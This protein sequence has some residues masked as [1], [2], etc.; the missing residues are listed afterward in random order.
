MQINNNNYS[1]LELIQMLE[2]KELIV[3]KDYQRGSGLWPISARA[4]FI[5]TILQGFPFPKIYMYEYLD[6]PARGMKK[7]I[8]DGQQ[9]ISSIV[10]FYNNEFPLQAEG[11]NK[12]KR[13]QELD[14]EQQEKFLSYSASVDVIRNATKADILQMFRRMNAYTMPLNDAEKRHSSFHGD[15]KWFIN[16]LADELNEFFVEFNVLDSLNY[17]LGSAG[18]RRR[19]TGQGR[20]ARRSCRF[21]RLSPPK[22]PKSAPSERLRLMPA[23]VVGRGRGCRGR[24][25]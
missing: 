2:R 12:G 20:F 14:E 9:R 3:N 24:R 10:G 1:V 15:F 21:R 4:F 17:C 19:T 25:A 6:R 5:D 22:G 13:F 11:A 23:A 18:F 7:E 8:V 16:E